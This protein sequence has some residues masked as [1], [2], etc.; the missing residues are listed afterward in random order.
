MSLS[1]VTRSIL[2][3]FCLCCLAT[4]LHASTIT[5]DFETLTE[6]TSVD[7]AFAPDVTF[8]N[9]VVLTAGSLLNEIDFPPHSGTNVVFDAGSPIRLDF[10]DTISSFS[11]YFTYA[12]ALT[13]QFYDAAANLLG[14]VTSLS[15]NN[16][17]AGT[18]LSNEL[19]TG[20]FAGTSF[21][22]IGGSGSGSSFVLD[23]V[24]FDTVE[25]QTVPEPGTALLVLTGIPFLIRYNSRRRVRCA[26]RA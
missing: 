22:T 16:T 9:A 23:D 5:I 2:F 24:A 25:T 11:G 14:E 10:A 6:G 20:A 26:A 18:G 8:T 13:L 7:A 21:V 12:A 19:L 4:P 17:T 3:G 1:D 15:D